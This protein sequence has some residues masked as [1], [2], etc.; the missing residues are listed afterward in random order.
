MMRNTHAANEPKIATEIYTN[1]LYVNIIGQLV[2]MLTPSENFIF[3]ERV[4]NLPSDAR[5]HIYYHQ[6]V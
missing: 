4:S 1:I 3:I 2:R 5:L 6:V